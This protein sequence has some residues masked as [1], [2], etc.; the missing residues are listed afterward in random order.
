[1]LCKELKTP[2]TIYLFYYIHRI[3]TEDTEYTEYTDIYFIYTE[4]TSLQIID[5]LKTY[6][7][8]YDV[9]M[10]TSIFIIDYNKNTFIDILIVILPRTK[11][12]EH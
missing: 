4:K 8:V 12:V 5:S 11:V 9:S 2:Y 1:M 10:A 3:Y 7:Y 6:R